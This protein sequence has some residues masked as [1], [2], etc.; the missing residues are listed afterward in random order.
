M[1]RNVDDRALDIISINMRI[2]TEMLEMVLL[3]V[4]SPSFFV[5][6]DDVIL[7]WEIMTL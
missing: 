6:N 2:P 7:W 3:A 5:S 1:G 4:L